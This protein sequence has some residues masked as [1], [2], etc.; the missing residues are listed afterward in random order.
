MRSVRD[1][2]LIDVQESL[3]GKFSFFPVKFNPTLIFNL[4]I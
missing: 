1:D 2:Q 3:E 4:K